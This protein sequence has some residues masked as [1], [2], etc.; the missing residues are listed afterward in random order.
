[1]YKLH[2]DQCGVLEIVCSPTTNDRGINRRIQNSL[3]AISFFFLFPKS[4][5]I[6]N[7]AEGVIDM[8]LLLLLFQHLHRY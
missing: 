4:R 3:P 6:E 1:M 8:L 7:R 5:Y 2:F